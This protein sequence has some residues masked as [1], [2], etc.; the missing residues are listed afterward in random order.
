MANVEPEEFTNEV[1][2]IWKMH[3]QIFLIFITF[4]L[5]M[6]VIIIY[7]SHSTREEAYEDVRVILLD[8]L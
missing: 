2:P 4:S 1:V 5:V 8:L 7:I 6:E 3:S